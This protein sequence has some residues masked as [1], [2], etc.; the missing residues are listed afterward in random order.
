MLTPLKRAIWGV[1]ALGMVAVAAGCGSTKANTGGPHVSTGFNLTTC[2]IP[3]TFRVGTKTVRSGSCAGILPNRPQEITLHRGDQVSV[4]I[5]HDLGGG[6]Y[7]PVPSP[8]G[9]GVRLVARH[10]PTV[11]YQ[12]VSTGVTQL[13]ARHT[14]YCLATD[15]DIGT[16]SALAIRVVP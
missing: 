10:G 3:Y 16:C 6:L 5:E 15:P 2:E 12:A 4:E 11:T 9:T 14:K 13:L 7:Y 8:H 1:G